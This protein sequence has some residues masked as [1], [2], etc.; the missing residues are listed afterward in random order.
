MGTVYQARQLSL[1]RVVALKTIRPDLCTDRHF[2][3]RFRQEARTVGRFN[4][5]YVVQ[6]HE[7]GFDQGLHY[8]VMEFVGGGTIR[9]HVRAHPDQRLSPDEALKFLLEAAR[10]LLE[11]ERLGII[12]RDIKPGNLLLDAKGR[13]KIADFGIAK[14]LEADVQSTLTSGVDVLG[15]PLY[16]SPEQ[17]AGEKLD[18][19]S[20][21]YAL[22]ASFF[23]LLTATPPVEGQ[24]VYEVIKRKSV[25]EHLSPR[26]I[27]PDDRIPESLSLII[28]RMTALGAGDRYA[29]FQD[30]ID[31]IERAIAGKELGE[32]V[33]RP[34]RPVVPKRR[35]WLWAGVAAALLVAGAGGYIAVDR[36]G[37]KPPAPGGGEVDAGRAPVTR[38]DAGPETPTKGPIV[39]GP[40]GGAPVAEGRGSVAEGGGSTG[41]ARGSDETGQE[42]SKEGPPEDVM[43]TQSKPPPVQLEDYEGRVAQIRS[44][45]SEQGP[46]DVLL[47]DAQRLLG[48]LPPVVETQE[49]RGAAEALLNDI[50]EGKR[51][52][53]ALLT[54]S[55]DLLVLEPPFEEAVAYW[56]ELEEVFRPPPSAGGELRAWLAAE[57]SRRADALGRKLD[58]ALGALVAKAREELGKLEAWET[59]SREFRLVVDRVERSRAA[60]REILPEESERWD[61]GLPPSLAEELAAAAKRH[62]ANESLLASLARRVAEAE[63]LEAALAS[64]VVGWS[65]ESEKRVAAAME[66]SGRMTDSLKANIEA[67]AKADPK[68][69]AAE[70]RGRLQKVA[71]AAAKWS[72]HLALWRKA[73]AA[74]RDRDLEAL[75]A[76][77]AGLRTTG[78]TVATVDGLAA[79]RAAFADGFRRLLRDLDLREGKRK[80]LEAKERLDGLVVPGEGGG[81]VEACIARADELESL[82]AGMAPVRGGD[83][84]VPER[85]ASRQV[86]VKSFFIDRRETSVDE[87]RKFVAT[88]K[89]VTDYAAVK[90]LWPDERTFASYGRGEGLEPAY[91]NEVQRIDP[92]WPVEDVNYYQAQ[93]YL[94]WKGKDLPFVGEW[95]LAARGPLVGGKHTFDAPSVEIHTHPERPA[96]VDQAYLARAFP[97]QHPVHHIAG[98]VAEWCKVEDERASQAQLVGGRFLDTDRRYFSGERRDALPLAR[99]GRGYGFRGVLRPEEFFG[100]LRPRGID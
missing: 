6:I 89:G 54:R 45:F 13:V 17:A 5:E 73:S 1:D 81:W 4:T 19:R 91:F 61:R 49:L 60:L 100:D 24:S 78:L 98:N 3:A 74:A 37:R 63:G 65:P 25:T 85:G 95:F 44:R 40:S 56:R 11:A 36:L 52:E 79:A 47:A 7:V 58:P 87:Y 15:T 93:A 77:I 72:E 21:M 70:I 42:P 57:R 59:G 32:L 43:R 20:D 86:S 50:G 41:E 53:A 9:D 30:L 66:E 39:V 46:T 14:V 35:R 48:D 71:V 64:E 23:Q 2:L 10:G 82:V 8:I 22:G 84:L 33:K 31:D 75:D 76:A 38:K 83:A 62:E 27:V 67:L 16:M 51:R 29:S 92:K 94:R 12:H 96:P 18:H 34:D 88:F 69:P 90:H 55:V 26:R 28:E 99:S 97:P 68:A 80:L